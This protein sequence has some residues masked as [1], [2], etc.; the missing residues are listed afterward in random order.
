MSDVKDSEHEKNTKRLY[1]KSEIPISSME[2]KKILGDVSQKRQEIERK[3]AEIKFLKSELQNDWHPLANASATRA[4]TSQVTMTVS[5]EICPPPGQISW[6]IC[7]P[8]AKFPRKFVPPF[9]NLSP[10]KQVMLD[11]L[12]VKIY[13]IFYESCVNIRY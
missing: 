3:E 8:R 7:P 12:K 11:F 6:E 10:Y 1:V 2:Y 4:E 13:Y 5:Q 9:G